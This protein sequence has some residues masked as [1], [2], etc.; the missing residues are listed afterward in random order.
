M[1]VWAIAPFIRIFDK[2]DSDVYRSGRAM[3]EQTTDIRTYA[4]TS[5]IDDAPLQLK[6]SRFVSLWGDGVQCP[7]SHHDSFSRAARYY[8]FDNTYEHKDYDDYSDVKYWSESTRRSPNL[9]ETTSTSGQ[10]PSARS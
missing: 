6:G 9:T 10:L 4:D 5:C 3:H 7:E 8:M 1:T 2:D